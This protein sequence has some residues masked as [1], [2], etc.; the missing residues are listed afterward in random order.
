MI[1]TAD[2]RRLRSL[3]A[4]SANQLSEALGSGADALIVD[5]EDSAGAGA[6]AFFLAK[7]RT[8]AAAPRLFVRPRPLESGLVDADLEAVMPAAPDGIALP[9][10]ASG[11]DVQRLGAKL[12]V[13][14]AEL[15]FADGATEIIAFAT[16]SARA[17]FGL[18]SYAGASSRL[19]G[20]VWDPT[21]LRAGVK[22]RSFR[23]EGGGLTSPYR[24]ARDLALFAAAAAGVAPIEGAY[25]DGGEAGL[26]DECL[27][28]R[29]DGFV[30]KIAIDPAQVAVIND[31]FSSGAG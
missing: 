8:R 17:L 7:A 26:R 20:L 10:C 4:V 28:A 24:L 3:L 22:S 29:R 25:L 2:G 31:M 15:G 23:D 12:A 19:A 13:Y 11:G 14:E 6:A 30:A 5:I 9:G 1:L 18:A 27:A 21:A 16:A